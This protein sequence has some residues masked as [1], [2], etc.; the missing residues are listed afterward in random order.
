MLS[1]ILSK[2]LNKIPN[3]YTLRFYNGILWSE[4]RRYTYDRIIVQKEKLF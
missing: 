2:S 1:K 3:I 4:R